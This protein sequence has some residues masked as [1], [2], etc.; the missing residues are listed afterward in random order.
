MSE[1]DKFVQFSNDLFSGIVQLIEQAKQKLAVHV[2]AETTLLYW[3]IG[4]FI[5]ENL[6]INNKLEYGSK[7]LATL[8]QQLTAPS[9]HY[10]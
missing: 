6:K 9:L 4:H 2:N 10:L 1:K 5:N 7:I 3:N 8:S